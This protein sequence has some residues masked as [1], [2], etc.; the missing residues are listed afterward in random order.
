MGDI[1]SLPNSRDAFKMRLAETYPTM[2]AG[3]IPVDAG[4][5][6]KFVHDVLPGDVLIYPSK[7]DRMINIGI[8]GAKRWHSASLKPWAEDLPNHLEV[9]WK[10][11]FPRSDFSQAALNEIG[12]FISLF[13]VRKFA[14]EFLA[15]AGL[16][17]A[18]SAPVEDD[19]PVPDD[20]VAQTTSQLAEDNAA[21]YI[22][23]QLHAGLNGY[24]FVLHRPRHA[25]HGVHRA[26]F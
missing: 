26:G 2:K 9:S 10:G 25:L 23:R 24:D 19:P 16:L 12:S 6:F 3:A 17:L 20:V 1:A 13:R 8:A 11:Q 7:H 14:D 22:I 18:P 5:M 21:D 15:K 4:T